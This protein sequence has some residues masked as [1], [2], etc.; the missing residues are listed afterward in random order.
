MPLECNKI[1]CLCCKKNTA[2]VAEIYVMNVML[3]LLGICFSSCF[4]QVMAQELN[5]RKVYRFY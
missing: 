5:S 1:Q 2:M 3:S 4:K